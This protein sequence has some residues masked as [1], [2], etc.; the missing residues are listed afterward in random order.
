LRRLRL[1]PSMGVALVSLVLAGSGGAYA[2]TTTSATITVCVSEKGGGLYKTHRCARGDRLLT[3]NL[4][5]PAGPKGNTGVQGAP[6][7]EG[8]PGAR[9]AQ[10]VP[11]IQGIAGT[12]RAYGRIDGTTVTHSKNIQSVTNPSDGLFCVALDPSIDT[13]TTVPLVQPDSNGDITDIGP[14]ASI[15]WAEG[16]SSNS[17][18]GVGDCPA[19]QLPVVTGTRT[20]ETG[21]VNSQTVVTS[22]TNNL[23][24]QPFFIVVP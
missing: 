4:A 10:G 19:G 13:S 24:D 3:W 22:V 18:G 20:E 12:A 6:G 15:A 23:A 14:N 5:G 17:V 9:G 16:N 8:M 1:T 21:T 7:A 11:G 2:V